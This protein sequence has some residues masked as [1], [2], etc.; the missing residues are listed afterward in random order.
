MFIS[1]ILMTSKNIFRL[2]IMLDM[3]NSF[4]CFWGQLDLPNMKRGSEMFFLL[5]QSLTSCHTG[6]HGAS[7]CLTRRASFLLANKQILIVKEV[8]TCITAIGLLAKS[9]LNPP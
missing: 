4:Q 2:P 9:N 8:P 6:R 7:A 1:K 5:T 3:S